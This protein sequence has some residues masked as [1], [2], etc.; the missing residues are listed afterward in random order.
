MESIKSFWSEAW[1]SVKSKL[2]EAW[3]NIKSS[4]SEGVSNVVQFF[5]DLPGNI[6]SALGDV[7]SMLWQAG[8]EDVYK[9]QEQVRPHVPP[10]G[11]GDL[12]RGRPRH[13]VQPG[14]ARQGGGELHRGRPRRHGQRVGELGVLQNLQ[15]A[16]QVRLR[17][18]PR[19]S[20]GR[21]RHLSLIH[22]L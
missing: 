21:G 20:V 4:V 19:R 22:I 17:S 18:R 5:T 16:V 10:V 12:V 9:R 15:D 7:G 14:A 6:I 2:S 3:E 1:E 8:S 11:G 13:H